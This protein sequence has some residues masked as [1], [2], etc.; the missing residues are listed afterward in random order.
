MTRLTSEGHG[1]L[2]YL[3]FDGR[4]AGLAAKVKATALEV[5]GVDT[6][7]SRVSIGVSPEARHFT[8]IGQYLIANGVTRVRLLTNNP[9]KVEELMGAGISVEGQPLL[10]EDPNEK[11]RQLY[12]TKA[13]K[14][15]HDIPDVLR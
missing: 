12:K 10:V 5:S 13:T 11:V 1:I 7:D 8:A 9:L 14:F 4:G 3:R 6:Y 15:Q 2:F